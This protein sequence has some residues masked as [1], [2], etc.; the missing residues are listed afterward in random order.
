MEEDVVAQDVPLD[1]LQEGLPAALQ[2]LEEVGAAEAHQ[3]L[4]GA[5]EVLQ[6]RRFCLASAARAGAAAR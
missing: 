4:A 2:P 1:R 3:A 5:G 6:L